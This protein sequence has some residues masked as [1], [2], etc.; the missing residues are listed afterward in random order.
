MAPYYWAAFD[1]LFLKNADGSF[2]QDSD[3]MQKW[4][5]KT[6]HTQGVVAQVDYIPITGQPFSGI[7]AQGSDTAV[8]RLS[9]TSNLIES[10]KGLF[11]SVA[12]KFLIDGRHS[13]NIFGVPNFTGTESWDFFS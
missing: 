4:R 9:Q 12:L 3:E 10:S 13:T 5:L 11:P 1:D 2:C 7:Y 6:T 8:L